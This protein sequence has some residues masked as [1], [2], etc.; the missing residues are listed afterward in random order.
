MSRSGE[1][2]VRTGRI[3]GRRRGGSRQG[4]QEQ[5][6]IFWRRRPL[7]DI[8]PPCPSITTPSISHSRTS[9]GTTYH[10][11]IRIL[12]YY[13]YP[14]PPRMLGPN[15]IR[16][17]NRVSFYI[18]TSLSYVPTVWNMNEVEIETLRSAVSAKYHQAR[19]AAPREKLF[20]ASRTGLTNSSNEVFGQPFWPNV[21]SQVLTVLSLN[22]G[23]P[24]Q[25]RV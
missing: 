21:S 9:R 15:L 3:Q 16:Q 5:E 25:I 10:W 13:E 14:A 2:E 12:A 22:E 11:Y 4:L 19:G 1:Q 23:E 7:R 6:C 20:S 17:Q 8:P 24:R 18:T